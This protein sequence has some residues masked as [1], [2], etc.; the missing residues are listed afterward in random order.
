MKIKALSTCF[1]FLFEGI[2]P[3]PCSLIPEQNHPELSAQLQVSIKLS[4]KC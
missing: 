3:L 1:G 2:F 4:E